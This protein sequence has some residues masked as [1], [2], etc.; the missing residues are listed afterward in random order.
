MIR[1]TPLTTTDEVKREIAHLVER[2]KA[3]T[4]EDVSLHRDEI[5][6]LL[7]S[8]P[9]F[10][11]E[12]SASPCVFRVA[13]L[14]VGRGFLPGTPWHN[15]AGIVPILDNVVL[16]DVKHELRMLIEMLNFIRA[17]RGLEEIKMPLFL[18]P[19][20]IL[21]SIRARSAGDD[22]AEDPDPYGDPYGDPWGDRERAAERVAPGSAERGGRRGLTREELRLAVHDRHDWSCRDCGETLDLQL[23]RIEGA[24]ADDDPDGYVTLCRRCL[25][26]AEGGGLSVGEAPTARGFDLDD[27]SALDDVTIRSQLAIVFH[28][29]TIRWVGFVFGKR[30]VL[31]KN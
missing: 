15:R 20:E 19:D 30:Y 2:Q 23:H 6:A 27:D 10:L 13:R 14:D 28:K 9:D 31:L 7:G 29:G 4:P 21:D 3:G 11:P 25:L 12:W 16:P 24:Y 22:R 26:R 18:Q 8:F 5:D 17:K 1:S